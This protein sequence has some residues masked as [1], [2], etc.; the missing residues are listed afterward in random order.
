MNGTMGEP[1]K[2]IKHEE[3]L[4]L[5][6]SVSQA[7][8]IET[9]IDAGLFSTK[10]DFVRFAIDEKLPDAIKSADKATDEEFEHLNLKDK[11]RALKEARYHFEQNK[12]LEKNILQ[13]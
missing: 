6:L 4:T 12:L 10:V 2:R 13:R 8:K 9:L 5:R 3:R 1:V 7:E 11:L